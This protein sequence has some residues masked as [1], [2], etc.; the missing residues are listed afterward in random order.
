MCF[1]K[2]EFATQ[3]GRI[4]VEQD[5]LSFQMP[6][7]PLAEAAIVQIGLELLWAGL[8][9]VQLL[10][11]ERPRDWVVAGIYSLLT[12]VRLP[13]AY[14]RL[15]RRNY[16]S[17]LQLSRIKAYKTQDDPHGVLTE[18]TLFLQN[19]RYRKILF[20]KREGQVEAFIACLSMGSVQATAA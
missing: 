17:R 19:D 3:Y 15:F 16:S 11:A 6:H 2:Q 7:R 18:L 8:F 13:T 1:R 4:V 14:D 20:R 12:V 5:I 10:T 9:F